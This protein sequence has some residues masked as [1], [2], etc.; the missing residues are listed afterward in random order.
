MG[1][2]SIAKDDP[3]ASLIFGARQ[4][5]NLGI[6]TVLR[7]WQNLNTKNTKTMFVVLE[8]LPSKHNL[9]LEL[10]FSRR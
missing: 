3:V 9:V 10:V 7:S 4:D 2:F 8:N 1:L 6:Y 5:Q